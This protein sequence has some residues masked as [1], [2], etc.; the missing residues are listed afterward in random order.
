[1]LEAPRL[2]EKKTYRD[3]RG[4]GLS[5]YQNLQLLLFLPL[6]GLLQLDQLLARHLVVFIFNLRFGHR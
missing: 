6:L 5:V 4:G 2:C 3:Q 1:M